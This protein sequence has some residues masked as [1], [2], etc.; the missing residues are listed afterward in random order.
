MSLPNPWP[1]P[2]MLVVQIGY[3][4]VT[5]EHVSNSTDAFSSSGSLRAGGAFKLYNPLADGLSF[6]T[7][8]HYAAGSTPGIANNFFVLDGVGSPLGLPSHLINLAAG[9]SINIYGAGPYMSPVMN[10]TGLS[11]G[12]DNGGG[13]GSIGAGF[14]LYGTPGYHLW[15]MFGVTNGS[16]G[17]GTALANTGDNSMQYNYSLREYLPTSIGQLEFGYYGG[18]LAEPISNGANYWTN[19]IIENGIDADLAN[20]T[21]ELGATFSE[22][23]DSNPYAP[24]GY[25]LPYGITDRSN[26]YQSMSF[27]AGYKFAHLITEEGTYLQLGYG[28]Y[29][30]NHEQ[31]QSAFVNKS[32][33]S[34]NYACNEAL[35]GA[36]GTLDSVDC[37]EGVKDNFKINLSVFLAA[38]V[39]M[40]F[41]YNISNIQEDNIFSTGVLFGF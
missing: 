27:Y 15:Y 29:T 25:A 36:V 6:Y 23:S 31:S 35:Y 32:S 33:A 34:A 7:G 8:F 28:Q 22:V 37:F 20:G 13:L 2:A 5:N 9:S 10:P 17:T 16:K 26:G 19:Q 40:N 1:I 3:Q 39:V 4:H 24:N 11:V 21:Y 12:Y 14:Q 30:Y 41:S 38:N 18:T